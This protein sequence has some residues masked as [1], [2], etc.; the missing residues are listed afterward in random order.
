M[1]IRHFQLEA[2]DNSRVVRIFQVI[3]GILCI[4]VA[5]YWTI[6]QFDSLR[7]DQTLWI[8]IF[9]LVGFGAYQTAAGL[10]R[11]TR[12]IETGPGA[13]ILKLNAYLPAARIEAAELKKVEIYPLSICFRKVNGKKLIL[14][15]GLN[16]TDIIVPVKDEIVEFARINNLPVEEMKEEL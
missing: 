2:R 15:F 3:F 7:K 6:F 1:E 12:Y 4:I 5:L 11:I 13:V 14:R 8:T 9:F 10:G 16:Y